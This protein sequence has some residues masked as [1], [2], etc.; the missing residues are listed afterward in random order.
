MRK[1][2]WLTTGWL[3]VSAI[4]VTG[5]SGQ[6]QE[7]PEP[8]TSEIQSTTLEVTVSSLSISCPASVAPALQY[9]TARMYFKFKIHNPNVDAAVTLDKFE[10]MV[11]GNEYTVAGPDAMVRGESLN[12]TIEPS[13]DAELSSPLPYISKDDYPAL[14]SEMAKE[15]VTWRIEGTAYISTSNGQMNVPFECFVKE[16]HIDI[17][18]NCLEVE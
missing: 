1:S 17:D 6:A 16:Y 8:T 7:S 12:L 5:C 3:A 2:L 10:Y 9:K 14:W 13:G 4:L 18:E 15:N 11:Y